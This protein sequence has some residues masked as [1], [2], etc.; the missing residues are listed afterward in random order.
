MSFPK[1]VYMT[2]NTPFFPILHVFAPLNDVRAYSAWSWKTTL[3]TWIFGRAWYP[4][5]HS[6]GPPGRYV[7]CG[8]ID[9][10]WTN[11]RLC[12]CDRGEVIIRNISTMTSIS[13]PVNHKWHT[14]GNPIQYVSENKP[15]TNLWIWNAVV[16]FGR[17]HRR[18][19]ISPPI[20]FSHFVTK[21]QM[22]LYRVTLLME[23]KKIKVIVGGV[24]NGHRFTKIKS[25]FIGITLMVQRHSSHNQMLHNV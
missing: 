10:Q 16:H 18:H 6:S 20:L 23:T 19:F 7:D 3:I 9:P 21:Y 13:Y 14:Q 24:G 22:C 17:F 5:W 12:R 25:N 11:Q 4:P 8:S 1:C 2:K 15:D